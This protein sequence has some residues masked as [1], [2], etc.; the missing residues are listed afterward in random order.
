MLYEEI[1]INGAQVDALVYDFSPSSFANQA[2]DVLPIVHQI[3]LSGA[4]AGD[5]N[6]FL[7]PA[8]GAALTDT[9]PVVVSASI[10]S[11]Q[12]GCRLVPKV[13][14]TPWTLRLTSPTVVNRTIRIWWS[15]PA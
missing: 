4:A 1:V 15:L 8:V 14:T 12:R 9:I 13:G 2:E 5:T 7:A 11:A 10:T 6:L 3:T